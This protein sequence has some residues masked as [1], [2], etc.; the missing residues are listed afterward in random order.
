MNFTI[1]FCVQDLGFRIC[2]FTIQTGIG[3]AHSRIILWHALAVA[4][5]ENISKHEKT[6]WNLQGTWFAYYTWTKHSRQ[7]PTR[8]ICKNFQGQP[9]EMLWPG[10]APMSPGFD[11]GRLR[12]EATEM[13]W[14]LGGFK[15][16][17]SNCQVQMPSA[18]GTLGPVPVRL[19]SQE[20]MVWF[21]CLSYFFE[22]CMFQNR[23]PNDC[24]DKSCF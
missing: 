1:R 8:H 19:S 20:G 22:M 11:E 18:S 9:G 7:S 5:V 16:F 23:L 2:P 14:W 12:T 4:G 15:G 21:Q 13:A 3:H 17:S 6:P 10:T 24:W